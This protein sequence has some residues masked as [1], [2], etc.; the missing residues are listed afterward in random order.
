MQKQAR[1]TKENKKNTDEFVTEHVNKNNV[2]FNNAFAQQ[3]Q[4][5]KDY[6]EKMKS[7]KKRHSDKVA[8]RDEILAR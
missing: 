7:E 1:I 8:A 5:A 4:V 6:R 2:R 3:E